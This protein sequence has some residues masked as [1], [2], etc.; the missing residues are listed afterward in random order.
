[1]LRNI[2]ISLGYGKWKEANIIRECESDRGWEND[3]FYA[4][5]PPDS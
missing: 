4:M 3:C 1:M 5:L 2:W